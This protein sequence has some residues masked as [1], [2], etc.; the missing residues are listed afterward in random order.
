MAM[1]LQDTAW[2]GVPPSTGER[3][4]GPW[5]VPNWLACGRTRESDVSVEIFYADNPSAEP[6][7]ILDTPALKAWAGAGGRVVRIQA[8][9]AV[10]G[11]P[12]AHGCLRAIAKSLRALPKAQGEPIH[13]K[14]LAAMFDGAA[15]EESGRGHQR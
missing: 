8:S 6:K 2:F 4:F 13:A 15:R 10:A 14:Y 1:A 9:I 3:G 12:T 5:E 7:M 11:E